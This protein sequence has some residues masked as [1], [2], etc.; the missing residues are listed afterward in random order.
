MAI[1]PYVNRG[2][3]LPGTGIQPT[4]QGP[5]AQQQQLWNQQTQQQQQANSTY[6][7]NQAGVQRQRASDMA[8]MLM[9]DPSNPRTTDGT[10]YEISNGGSAS[11]GSRSSG[12]MQVGGGTYPNIAGLQAQFDALNKPIAP[13]QRIGAPQVPQGTSGFAH[14]KDVAGRSGNKALEAFR[15]AMTARGLSDSGMA[16]VGEAEIM[17]NVARQGSDAE[18]AHQALNTS[19]QWDANKMAYQGDIGQNEME[20]TNA[21]GQRNASMQAILQLMNRLY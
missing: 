4:Q 20:Y 19:R 14:A 9:Q 18:Y 7:A 5:S 1:N 15:N 13:P 8:Y 6:D 12:G 10:N 16:G 17:G 2:V 11:G 21:I 3:Q